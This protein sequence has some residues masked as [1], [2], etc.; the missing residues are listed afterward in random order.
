MK[1][2]WIIGL[3]ENSLQGSISLREATAFALARFRPKPVSFSLQGIRFFEAGHDVWSIAADVYI[4]RVYS[5][6]GM[7]IGAD[8]VVV[9]IG[10]HKGVFTGYA[11]RRTNNVVIAY[12]PNPN[13]YQLLITF[14][15]SNRF[16]NIQCHQCAI[17][18]TSGSTSLYLSRSSTRH[19]ITGIDQVSGEQ[20]DNAIDVPMISLDDVLS[21]LDIVDFLKVDCEGAEIEILRCSSDLTLSKIRKMAV[22]IH[23][24]G[25][26]EKILSLQKRL[27]KQFSHVMINQE[28]SQ[29]F[30]YIY[31]WR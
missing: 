8:D 3:I 22:E 18:H 9:D 26:S 21:I 6:P 12:E 25:Q 19:S 10:A 7:E 30:G 11:A 23:E 16:N 13:N 27:R 31:A 4:N 17:G 29:K 1:G 14:L 20:L 24:F 5:P 15:K 28:Q 2:R